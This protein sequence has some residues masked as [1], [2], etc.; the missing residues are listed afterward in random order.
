MNIRRMVVLVSTAIIGIS[1]ASVCSLILSVPSGLADAAGLWYVTPGGSDSN[2][3]E[4]E[5]TPCATINGAISKASPADIIYVATGTYTGTASQI[6]LID[7]DI[8]LSG[9]WDET[10]TNQESVSII[11]G[12]NSRRGI[13]LNSDVTSFIDHFSIQNG[14]ASGGG[15]IFTNGS[16]TLNNCS[17]ISNTVSGEGGGVFIQFGGSLTLYES[18]VGNNKANSG[19]GIFSAWGTLHINNSTLYNNFANGG[20]GINN[21]GGTVSLNSTTISG[22]ELGTMGGGGIRNEE[23]GSVTLQNTIIAG[24]SGEYGP[25]CN[26]GFI[27]QGYNL[28]GD[29][30]ECT[31]APAVGDLVNTYPGLFPTLMGSPAYYPLLPNSM[32]IDAGNPSGCTDHTASILSIDQRGSARSVDG[33]GDGSPRCDMGA[34]EYD[35]SNPETYQIS[36]P[37]VFNNHCPDFFDDFSNPSSGWPVMDNDYELTEYFNG[38][39]R[40][41]PKEIG[42][43]YYYPAPTCSREDYVVEVNARWASTPGG[44]YGLMFG[45]LTDESQFY[46]LEIDTEYQDIIIWRRDTDGWTGIVP[47]TYSSAINN[48]SA[49]NHI[50]IKRAGVQFTVEINDTVLGTWSDDNLTGSSRVGVVVFP[51]Y[52]QSAYDVRFDN[53]SVSK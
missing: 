42:Y 27:S 36:L 53:F 41:A 26:G 8:T 7:K 49:S 20:G 21:L 35:P 19:G 17:V 25:D 48:G 13:L 14:S 33:N 1:L 37:C 2:S 24:N 22:N 46:T 30:S 23:D 34:Y 18:S 45:L 6:V 51:Y 38:E 40:V 44:S 11:D 43:T 31:F 28:I 29:N 5:S 50:K 10:F 32:A 4:S 3:C 16:L 12:E 52:D 39:Y 9:G 15:G 47:Y